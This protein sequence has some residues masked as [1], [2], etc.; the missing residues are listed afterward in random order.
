MR[1][2]DFNPDYLFLDPMTMEK[3]LSDDEQ[4]KINNHKK[5]DHFSYLISVAIATIA[6]LCGL[7]AEL[8]LASG[9]RNIPIIIVDCLVL[10]VLAGMAIWHLKGYFEAK[11]MLGKGSSINERAYN[12]VVSA[13]KNGT[14]YTAVI[15]IA[16]KS[17]DSDALR[18]LCRE[19]DSFL[20][21]CPLNPD[22]TIL[23]AISTVKE[24]IKDSFEIDYSDI[25]EINALD[26]DPMF[27]VKIIGGKVRSVALVFYSVQLDEKVKDKIHKRE[28][29]W[30]SI[31][32]MAADPK[33]MK[34]NYDVIERLQAWRDR[35]SD[36][37][38]PRSEDLHVIW[39]ITQKCEYNCSICATRIPGRE[40]VDAEKKLRILN[41]LAEEKDRIKTIDFAGGDPCQSDETVEII[42]NAMLLFGEDKVSVTTTAKGIN[43]LPKELQR[44]ILARCELTFDAAHSYLSPD[45]N[46]ITI[47]GAENYS[48]SNAESL[49][50]TS[51]SIRKLTIN[52]PI[53]NTDLSM[54][55]INKLANEI[56]GI[57]EKYK[58]ITVDAKL[59]RLMPVGGYGEIANPDE[60]KTYNPLKVAYSIKE[61][62]NE[63][64]ISCV[65]HCSLRTL[66]YGLNGED[67]GRCSMLDRK[68]GIDC[69][70]N[71]FACAWGGYLPSQKDVSQNPFYIGNII[72]DSLSNILSSENDTN[73]YRRIRNKNV[74]KQGRNY[75][76]VVSRYFNP[77]ANTNC[78]PLAQD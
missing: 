1:L 20:F 53:L 37:F 52:I 60:Y 39:N 36:S 62:L 77:D 9:N 19:E 14:S 33:A 7:I 58:D 13:V 34:S 47:R 48:K 11:R 54:E 8:R 59:I 40:E 26:D 71:V 42:K 30:K 23:G 63:R 66:D 31:D 17:N 10:A 50:I 44:S 57:S 72:N 73:A 76:E 22:L 12:K 46:G 68:I 15:L 45:T 43:K 6:P 49:L 24:T 55:E 61:A 2:C 27:T 21:H 51:D 29:T 64:N 41:A 38:K 25:K 5:I 18:F 78:D 32:E 28:K 69:A 35:L 16:Y 70:G 4:I 74:N 3:T 65:F 75:C 56:K 67:K